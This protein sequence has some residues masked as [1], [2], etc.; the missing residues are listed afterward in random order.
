[1]EKFSV[2]Q[3]AYF[4]KQLFLITANKQKICWRIEGIRDQYF[5]KSWIWILDLD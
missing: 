2:L 4:C 3:S 1:L 5:Q